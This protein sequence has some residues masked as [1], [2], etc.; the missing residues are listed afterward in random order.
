MVNPLKPGHHELHFKAEAG[1][2]SLSLEV[3]YH[4][5]VSSKGGEGHGE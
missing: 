4:L 3:T 5:K 1:D 2:G